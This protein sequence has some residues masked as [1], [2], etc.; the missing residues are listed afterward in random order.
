M[1]ELKVDTKTY[2]LSYTSNGYLNAPKVFGTVTG[3]CDDLFMILC[4]IDDSE[5]KPK[6]MDDIRRNVA[7]SFKPKGKDFIMN[8]KT[9]RGRYIIRIDNHI[10]KLGVNVK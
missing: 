8:I 4:S 1:T 5:L 6:V 2:T 10:I 9:N 7:Q 3:V